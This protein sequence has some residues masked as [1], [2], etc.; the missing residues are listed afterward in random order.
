MQVKKKTLYKLLLDAFRKYVLLL[1]IFISE[2]VKVIAQA[3]Q[4]FV[5][6]FDTTATTLAYTI[7]ELCLNPQIQDKV[8]K[9]I[10]SCIL[11]HGG[12]TYDAFL[13]MKYLHQ[14]ILGEQIKQKKPDT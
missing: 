2:G 10:K 3:T 14:C 13:N 12:Y 8:R 11:E 6:G 9:E 5:A 7:Y 4:F 1:I